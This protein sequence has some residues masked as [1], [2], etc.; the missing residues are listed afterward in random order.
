MKVIL[1]MVYNQVAVH[2]PWVKDSKNWN[3]KGF[4]NWF[5]EHSGKDDKTSIKNWEDT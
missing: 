3:G 5:H 1:D 2:H 4:S